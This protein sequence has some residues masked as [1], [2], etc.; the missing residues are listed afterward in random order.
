MA[1]RPRRE[2]LRLLVLSALV[3]ASAVAVVDHVLVTDRPSAGSKGRTT[4]AAAPTTTVAVPPPPSGSTPG[5]GPGAAA[6]D[7]IGRPAEPVPG[8]YIVALAPSREDTASLARSVAADHGGRVL[9]VYDQALHGF[10]VA[11]D[12]AHA[13]QLASDRRVVAVYQDGIVHTD[14]TES[15]APWDLDRLDQA[16]LPLDDAFTVSSNGSTVHAYVIDSGIRTTHQDFGGRAS[17]GVD[18]VGDGWNGQDCLGHGTF[19]AGLLGGATYGVAKQVSLTSVRVIGCAGTGTDSQVI[20]GVDWVTAHAVKPA[21]ANMSLSGDPY[22]PLE[23]AVS[24]SIASGITYVVAAGN[25]GVDACGSSP[26]LVP[27]AI[28]VAATDSSDQRASWSN[29]GACVDLFAPGVSD[30]SASNTGDADGAIGS[31]T[32]FAAPLVAGIAAL[33]LDRSPSASP[34]GVAS[35]LVSAS[36]PGVV[37]DAGAGSPNRLALVVV[38]PLT[39]LP[40]PDER[41]LVQAIYRSDPNV[42]IA[43]VHEQAGTFTIGT[44]T[45]PLPAFGEYQNAASGLTYQTVAGASAGP[46]SGECRPDIV[47]VG[48]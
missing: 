45:S 40:E 32:S 24:N 42:V 26:A 41:D 23:T 20:A 7:P 17:V 35:G 30:I 31:G 9:D 39:I 2:I 13:R 1:A 3:V 15:P 37:V 47:S 19:V 25:S 34:A 46:L 14:G 36:S 29:Y 10:A 48:G 27:A 33:V 5:A 22:A 38:P 8:Q 44:C 28:T 21:V 16:T 4:A 18:E 6:T 11:M 12:D 43:T